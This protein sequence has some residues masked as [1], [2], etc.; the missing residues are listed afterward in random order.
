MLDSNPKTSIRC[1]SEENLKLHNAGHPKEDNNFQVSLILKE[2]AQVA[3]QEIFR[4]MFGDANDFEAEQLGVSN[5]DMAPRHT[6]FWEALKLYS[7]SFASSETP[8]NRFIAMSP[9]NDAQPWIAKEVMEENGIKV[10]D[11][12]TLDLRKLVSELIEESTRED[13]RESS[14]GSPRP[15]SDTL[16]TTRLKEIR[17]ARR[18][19][20]RMRK[21]ISVRR[22]NRKDNL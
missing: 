7:G 12:E 21:R 22:R 10:G 6:A 15:S 8:M 3:E 20:T 1:L 2:R 18:E 17:N 16:T 13:I 4:R 9:A 11:L 14:T 19:G 5:E